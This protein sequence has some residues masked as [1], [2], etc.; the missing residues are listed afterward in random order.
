M[1]NFMNGPREDQPDHAE[2]ADCDWDGE[3]DKEVRTV[4]NLAQRVDPGGEVPAGSCPDCGSLVYL[5]PDVDPKM[6]TVKRTLELIE[7][8]PR[9]NDVR[10]SIDDL[11]DIGGEFKYTVVRTE[12]MAGGTKTE[13]HTGNRCYKDDVYEFQRDNPNLFDEDDVLLTE[14]D[15]NRDDSVKPSSPSP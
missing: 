4:E 14:D 5:S 11:E 15:L 2:C 9:L 1:T 3:I 10:V 7:N 6:Q 13:R 8:N 12:K